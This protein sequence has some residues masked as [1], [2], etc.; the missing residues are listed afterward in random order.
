MA[1]L[2]L[3][4]HDNK[5]LKP[6]TAN[7]VTAAKALGQPVD[8]LVAGFDCAEVAG[9]ASALQGVGRV[10]HADD[11][12]L[13]HHSAEAVAPIIAGLAGGYEGVIAPA[14]G[15]AKNVLPRVAGMLDMGQVSDVMEILSPD[16]F[17]HPIYAGN[18][19][20]T[21]VARDPIKILTVRAS[22][23]AG[24]GKSGQLAPIEAIPLGQEQR[25]VQVVEQA[26]NTSDGPD[27]ASARVVVSGGRG[28]G[29]KE[30][31]Q[32]LERLAQSLD[33][34]IG[35]TRAAVDAGFIGN[36]S[37]VGQTGKMVAPELYFAVGIS[38]AIQHLAGILDSKV[39]V[40]I[41]NDPAAA[42]FQ[43]ADYGLVAD[44]HDALPELLIELTK[45]SPRQE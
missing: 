37:Q 45:L 40:A 24:A 34:A 39:I 23:F 25:G 30:A 20:E 7:A 38:G 4:D 36:H 12:A 8:V 43:V 9:G 17:V 21:V 27:L 10:L 29:T 28:M 3:A 33:A 2:V 31:F 15:F 5:A 14:D 42:I 35:A 6:A 16:T 26:L 22:A 44:L 13:R 19:L 32:M 1:V 11:G 41:N 18:A